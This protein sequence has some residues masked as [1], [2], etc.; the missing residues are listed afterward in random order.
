MQDGQYQK[1]DGSVLNI[2][3][4]GKYRVHTSQPPRGQIIGDGNMVTLN[5][6]GDNLTET[7]HAQEEPMSLDELI[8]I[9]EQTKKPMTVVHCG[10][11]NRAMRYFE[12]YRLKDTLSGMKVL[13]IGAS[14]S[15]R[16]LGITQEQTVNLDVL[17]LFKIDDADLV[18]IF[19]PGGY[20]G[21]STR[22]ELEYAIRLGKE[23]WFLEVPKE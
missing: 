12:E 20:I 7:I 3:G 10:P 22:R 16:S 14:K 19:N 1:G 6:H 21:P 15:D 17:H 9:K 8:A 23:I 13:T 2:S 4:G 11:T 5:F 18:R